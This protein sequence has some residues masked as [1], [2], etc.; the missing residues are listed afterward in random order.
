MKKLG[1][2]TKPKADRRTNVLRIL[3][4]VDERESLDAIAKGRMLD[5][6]TW[7]RIVLMEQVKLE[8]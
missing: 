5:T 7:A 6:S 4:K 3:L 8:K 2:P 1:R